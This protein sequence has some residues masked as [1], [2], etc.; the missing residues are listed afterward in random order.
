MQQ[1]ES[2]MQRIL[3]EEERQFTKEKSECEERVKRTK[4]E[5]NDVKVL[6]EKLKQAEKEIAI[7][8]IEYDKQ[9]ASGN[10]MD[11]LP[12]KHAQKV[13]ELENAQNVFVEL[14]N[15][16]DELHMKIMQKT[17]EVILFN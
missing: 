8:D 4:N 9:L 14:E 5:K 11:N 3:S 17:Q 2:E 10:Q 1:E 6:K 13:Q 15:K 12:I 7:K 16:K